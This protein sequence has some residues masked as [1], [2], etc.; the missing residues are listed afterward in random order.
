ADFLLLGAIGFV[1]IWTSHPSV[2]ILAGIGMMLVMDYLIKKAYAPLARILGLGFLWIFALGADYFV[3]LRYLTA[4][5]FLQSYW[6]HAF[7][8]L[9]LPKLA[10]W[11]NE[12]YLSLL[13]TTLGFDPRFLIITCSILAL[14]GIVRLVFRNRNIAMIILLPFGLA[15]IASALQKYPLTDR[16]MLFLVPLFILLMTEGLGQIYLSARKLNR[17]IAVMLVGCITLLTLWMPMN[18]G[19]QKFITPPM[20]NDIKPVLR[21]VA[22]NR[23]PNDIVYVYHTARPAFAYYAASYGLDTGKVITGTDFNGM[24]TLQ[25]FYS[26][27]EQLKGNSKVWFIFSFVDCVGCEGHGEEYF[28]QYLDQIGRQEN[29]FHAQGAD[30]YLYDLNP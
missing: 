23:N 4:N 7:M 28:I 10:N 27:A 12:T 18:S 30:A 3:S 5:G 16:F 15:L 13:K 8:P 1:A 26:A 21:Y 11:L 14:I 22:Q 6:R 24:L 17:P 25:E 9:Q 20:D 29:S 19:F 2:F